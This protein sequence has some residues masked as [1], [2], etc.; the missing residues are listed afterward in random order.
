KIAYISRNNT[1][2]EIYLYNLGDKLKN[3]VYR[4]SNIEQEAK[5]S[6]AA[7]SKKLLLSFNGNFIIIDAQDPK[8]I[9][10]LNTLI[11]FKPQKIQWDV[12]SDNLLYTQYKNAIYKI[13]L[14][15]KSS[16]KIFE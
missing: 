2:E 14:F 7:S 10:S 11:N 4:F 3:L 16:E 1:F 8:N 12:Q 15:N 13:D 9:T 5:I 6:W